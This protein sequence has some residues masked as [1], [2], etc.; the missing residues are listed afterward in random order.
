MGSVVER[1]RLQRLNGMVTD[2]ICDLPARLPV[3]YTIYSAY[4][5]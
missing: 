4:I 2:V 3:V 5:D 1:T